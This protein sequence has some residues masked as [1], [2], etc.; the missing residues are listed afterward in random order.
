M[1]QISMDLIEYLTSTNIFFFTF[2]YALLVPSYRML[3]FQQMLKLH[4]YN[5][6]AL[7]PSNVVFSIEKM[8]FASKKI[9]H[10]NK[11]LYYIDLDFALITCLN[12]LA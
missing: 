1:K 10:T 11:S 4:I 3:S 6:S 5:Y 9:Y 2:E 8:S 12:R 7:C